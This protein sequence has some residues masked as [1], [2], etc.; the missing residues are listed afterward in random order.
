MTDRKLQSL[1]RKGKRYE[2][3]DS[4]VP[5]FGV[6]VSE[7]GQKS[8]ILIARYPGSPNP[9]RRA[10]GEYPSMSL[11][12]A[13]ERAKDWR[14]I[15]KGIDPKT[16]EARLR[17]L[18]LRKQ[19][20]TF[21][22]VADDFI[23]RH[24]KGQ[25]K[26]VDTEREIRKELIA[27]WADRPVASIAREDVIALVE[28]IARRP[29]PYTAHIVLGHTRSLFN[30]A[31]NRGTYGLET[32]PC[33]RIKPATLIGAKQPRQRTLTDAELRALWKATE[34]LGYP[35]GSL[36]RL[37]LLTGARKS[38]VAGAEWSE[39]DLDKRVWLVPPERFILAR[40]DSEESLRWHL[41]PVRIGLLARR[42]LGLRLEEK[43]RRVAITRDPSANMP[44]MECPL[45][46]QSR[47]AQC[48]DKCPL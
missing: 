48:K 42:N 26:A 14:A 23:E 32:S 17:R 4:D 21:A 8:F 15:R 33:D 13:R 37:L 44:S 30:W 41:Q 20:T 2:V 45:V 24:V 29:A 35:F 39:F 6:R 1:K 3:M 10:L 7:V 34:T 12:E 46:A 5:G 38:E 25:R 28:A 11:G 40:G 16:E 43:P 36:Y 27:H 9:T 19:A 22:S 18:E 31:I 47:H